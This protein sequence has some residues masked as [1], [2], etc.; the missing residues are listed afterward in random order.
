M[1]LS[2]LHFLLLLPI[3]GH[4]LL[5]LSNLHLVLLLPIRGNLFLPPSIFNFCYFSQLK[6]AWPCY[7]QSPPLDTSP[8]QRPF[9]V[10]TISD[11]HLLLL[12]MSRGHFV[13]ALSNPDLVLLLPIRGR[14]LLPLS[15]LRLLLLLPIKGH[16]IVPL[17]IS[18]FC[19]LSQSEAV[20][21][22][23]Y[24]QS[25]PFTT[26]PSQRP[27]LVGTSNPHLLLLLP[28]EATS[29]WHFPT[30]AFCN[31]SH[32]R[33]RFVLALPISSFCYSSQP[34]TTCG[35]HFPISTLRYCA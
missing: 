12:Y 35:C 6:A 16:M 7:F 8:R 32:I 10:C 18:I 21:C 29:C 25:P 24:L 28:A 1:A 5:P 27:L 4:F 13:L 19:Y 2:N 17:P 26:S 22:C 11:L 3:R 30:S 34:E 31:F 9:R 23:H 20:S 33:G 15:H 14:F